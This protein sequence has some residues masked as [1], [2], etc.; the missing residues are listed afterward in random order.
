MSTKKA[1]VRRPEKSPAARLKAGRAAYMA[2]NFAG[3]RDIWLPLAEAGDAEAQAWVGS[4]YAN[5][6]GVDINDGTAFGWYL[7]SAEGGNVQA[8]SNI[9]AMYAMG[10]GV[11]GN[12]ALAYMWWSLAAAQGDS[13]ERTRDSRVVAEDAQSNK[14]ILEERMTREQIAEGQRLSREWLTAH[15]S[16][17]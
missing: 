12:D 2:E 15:P 4:L 5:G 1:K 13:S 14:D 8:Q 9:G 16:S 3:A 11:P 10:Q 6:D 7:K 17:A